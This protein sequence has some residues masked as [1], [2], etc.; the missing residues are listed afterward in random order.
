MDQ[1]EEG[2][3]CATSEKKVPSYIKIEDRRKAVEYAV[4]IAEKRD[5]IILAGKG[6]EKYQEIKGNR[7]PLDDRRIVQEALN[8]GVCKYYC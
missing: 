3:L 4:S 8:G 5:V 6:H 2:L 1:I 7:Y